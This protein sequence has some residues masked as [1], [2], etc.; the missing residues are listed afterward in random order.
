QLASFDLPIM[1]TEFGMETDDSDLHADFMRDL[2]TLTFSHPSVEGFVFREFW[3]GGRTGP[4][5]AMYQPDWTINPNGEVYRDL[6]LS[7]WWTDNVALSNADGDL[8]TRAFLGDYVIT[9]RKE[10]FSATVTTTL[11]AD[12]A[13]FT[14]KLDKPTSG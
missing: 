13:S 6:V 14:L 4:K 12:G 11:D 10:G 9:A 2:M 1:I 5:A 3:E 8:L 7:E